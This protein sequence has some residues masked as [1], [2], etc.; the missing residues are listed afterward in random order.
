M[1]ASDWMDWFDMVYKQNAKQN[2]QNPLMRSRQIH[3][4][5]FVIYLGVFCVCIFHCPNMGHTSHIPIQLA[6][7]SRK[8]SCNP[9]K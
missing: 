7:Y 8:V 1:L 6:F 4:A 5:I 9:A 3:T 2:D